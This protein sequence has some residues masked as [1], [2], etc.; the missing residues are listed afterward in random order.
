MNP[1][2]FLFRVVLISLLFTYFPLFVYAEDG[3]DL[4]D[5]GQITFRSQIS[6]MDFEEIDPY[7]GTLSLT[8]KDVSLPGNGG[9]DLNIY[10]T[11]RTDRSTDYTVLGSRWDTHFGRIKKNGHNHVSI[12]LQDGT[13]NSAVK[14]N[15]DSAFGTYYKYFTKDFWKI[16]M[17]GTP[18]LQLTDGTEII[19]GRGGGGGDDWYYATQIKRNNNTITINYVT[20]TIRR[21]NYVTDSTGRRIDFNYQLIGGGV[22]RLKEIQDPWN[23]NLVSY[24]YSGTGG[25]SIFQSATYPDG[26]SWSYQYSVFSMVSGAFVR[27]W[28][29]TI[30][31]PYG[32]TVTYDYNAFPRTVVGLGTKYQLSVSEKNISGS[33]ITAGTWTY[34]YGE[35]SGHNRDY[36]TINDSCSRTTTYN[37]Y[38]YS[39]D[40]DG[41]GQS[42]CFRYGLIRHKFTTNSSGQIEEAVEYTWDKLGAAISPISYDVPNACNDIDT[43]VPALLQQTIYRGGTLS[44][45]YQFTPDPDNWGVSNPDDTYTTRYRDF[46]AYGNPGTI[47]EYDDVP[48]SEISPA[49][50]TTTTAYWTNVSSNIVKGIPSSVRTQGNS[51]FPGDFTTTYTYDTYANLLIENHFGVTTTH[52]YHANRNLASIKDANNHTVTYGWDRGVINAIN[53][54]IYTISRSINWD[55]TVASET[56]GRNFTTSYT[57]TPGMRINRITPP[58]TAPVSNSTIFN[59]SFG[60]N[61]YTQKTRGG[62]FNTTYYDDLG[63]ERRTEDSIGKTTTT[64]YKACG[65]I[66]STSSNIGDTVNFDNLGRIIKITHLDGEDIDYLHHEDKHVEIV[67]EENKQSHQY[68]ATFGTPGDKFLTS[69]KDAANQ[70]GTYSYDILGGLLSASFGG[71]NRTFHYN[72]KH[73]LDWERHPESG[74]TNYTFDAV[75]NLKSKN[76]WQLPTKTYNY[77]VINRLRSVT[78]ST[79]TLSYDYDNADNLTLL[80][81]LDASVSYGYDSVNRMTSTSLTTLGVSNSLGFSYDSNDN[82]KTILY[83]SNKTV[84]YAYENG[85]NQVTGISGFGS[86]VSAIGYHTSGA[87]R[88]LLQNF[89]FGNGQST[90]LSYNNRRAMTGTVSDV[91]KLGFVYGDNRGNMTALTNT[92]DPTKNKSFTYDNISRLD[93]FNGPWG[94]GDFNY[95]ADG[96][97]SRK[98]RDGTIN[99]SYVSNRLSSATGTSY[100]YNLDG[101]MT[102]AGDLDFDYTPFHRMWQVSNSEGTLSFFGFDGNGQRVSKTA[103]GKATIY[104]RDFTGRVLTERDSSGTFY[105]DFIYLG[106]TMVAKDNKP[107]PN[108]DLDGDGLTYTEEEVLGTDPNNPDTDDDEVIDGIEVQLGTDPLDSDTDDD[109]LSDG[110]EVQL[111]TD[112]LVVDTDGDGLSDGNEV[113]LGTDPLLPDTD[114]DGLLDGNEVQIGTNPLLSDTDNDGL[115][116]G[117]EIQL[118]TDPLNPDT[119]G[120]GIEDGLDPYPLGD[121]DRTWMI[122]VIYWPLILNG[123]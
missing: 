37:F 72:S 58:L 45:F 105:D 16:N 61:T 95:N 77:D 99:Y 78:A 109:G 10:R 115:S 62:F 33:N 13:V 70:T 56:N 8:H 39:G 12:E 41:S 60:V 93:A 112:P 24:S 116:D 43:Y 65:L 17:Q 88:G 89:S 110:E 80:G 28:I 71:N 1:L 15:Y 100:G 117:D 113:Q 52:T 64:S 30:N 51:T 40:Y 98:V 82:L 26:E 23:K 50:K 111:G 4:A 97:R 90:T 83:P 34:F 87:Y 103:N 84:T 38:G 42:E 73:F 46:D 22:Y 18:T 69:V 27:R 20:G 104:L 119:D 5:P 29:D 35:D 68:Y 19:F 47:K 67:D 31:T 54:T 3:E 94:N 53:N 2:H 108:G 44:A 66:N 74:T 63:R 76:D 32:G 6:T 102:S 25:E 120:D 7:S 48:F 81:S 79:Q 106:N 91:L 85:L 118:G 107:D 92:L 122:P 96:D 75:G 121:P 123:Q 14:E 36:T 49:L 114:S 57:Y 59:Y 55:G 86:T 101:D 21:I 11:Y 9:L